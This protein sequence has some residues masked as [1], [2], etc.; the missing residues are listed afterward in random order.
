MV[1]RAVAVLNRMVRKRLTEQV[2]SV[3]RSEGGKAMSHGDGWGRTEAASTKHKVSGW[4]APGVLGEQQEHPC[5]WSRG[6]EVREVRFG[7]TLRGL[8]GHWKDAAL[9]LL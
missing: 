2:T 5:D 8:T 7:V 1:E 3:Q 6:S 9:W 4:G